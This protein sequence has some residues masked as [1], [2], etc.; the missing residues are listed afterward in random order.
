MLARIASRGPD[1]EATWEDPA[2]D[3]WLG[4]RRLSILDLSVAG[5]QPMQ[6]HSGRYVI[7]YNGEIYNHRKFRPELES[8]GIRF[9]GTSDTET[10]LGLIETRGL[11]A[12]LAAANGMFAFGLWDREKRSLYL[13]RDRLG[14]KPLVYATSPRGIAFASNLWAIAAVPE[15]DDAI[16]EAAAAAYFRHLAVPAPHTAICGARKVRPGSMLVWSAGEVR[17]HQWW[18][19]RDAIE[20]GQENPLRKK[21]A[22]LVDELDD[23][24]NDATRQQRISDV[25][26]GA[27]LSGGIDSSSV[28]AGMAQSGGAQ[29]FTIAFPGSANDESREAQAVARHLGAVHT[30]IEFDQ[31]DALRLVPILS[32]IYDEPFG[33][34]SALPTLLLCR[35]A[36]RQVTVALSGDGGDE[37]F[38][39]YPRYFFGAQ[40]DR[41]RRYLGPWG[42]LVAAA[43][44]RS[45]PPWLAD[46]ILANILPGG[47]GSEG[48]TARLTRLAL[49]LSTNPA[50]TYR[51]AIAVWPD[52]PILASDAADIE[53]GFA[54][55]NRYSSLSWPERMMA[56]DQESHLPD[57][58][59]TKVDRASMSIG[60]E[61]RVPL[62]DHRIVEWSW[63]VPRAQLLGQKKGSGSRCF[64]VR[65]RGAFRRG[66]SSAR[67]ADLARHSNSGCAAISRTGL[68]PF[69]AT[70]RSLTM[71]SSTRPAFARPGTILPAVGVICGRSGPPSRGSGGAARGARPGWKKRCRRERHAEGLSVG[72]TVR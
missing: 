58:L 60:L 35:A 2:A 15:L 36:R 31:Q 49:Y 52:P 51:R 17:A 18:S 56:M 9:R 11:D 5:V 19:I 70:T 22:A 27:F 30:T 39:G 50:D 14:I 55:I 62:L 28:V 25:P 44:L 45:T 4:H 8:K 41:A 1:G 12:A 65:S 61:V 6:S 23:L 53:T 26:L 24:I 13:V 21:Q 63:R 47:S 57:D 29:T 16:D 32:N 72:H 71:V 68:D 37:L 42:S 59:L 67:N 46:G 48:M 40:V 34:A 33:D 38:G 20:R 7:T 64:A 43:I 69:F 54:D 3:V 66:F 10:L